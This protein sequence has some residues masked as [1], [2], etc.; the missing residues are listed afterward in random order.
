M[1]YFGQ[2]GAYDNVP[3]G[4]KSD[5]LDTYLGNMGYSSVQCV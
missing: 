1:M 4:L 2:G 3:A 5:Y